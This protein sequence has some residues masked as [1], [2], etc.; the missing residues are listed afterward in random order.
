ML[1]LRRPSAVVLARLAAA[2]S[3]LGLT[4]PEVGATATAMPAR[5]W[6]GRWRA[7]L[8]E[9]SEARLHRA[10]D[11]LRGWAAQRGAGM[12]VVPDEPVRPD[13]TFAL[14]LPLPLGWATAAGRVVYV[15]D[16]PERFGFAYGTLPAHP[17]RG[18]EA[19]HVARDGARLVFTV[20]AFS[21]PQH[22]LARLGAPVARLIQLRTNRAY[23]T[24][25]RAA[26][27]C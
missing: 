8:G 1:Y 25:M 21:R 26:V 10:S 11:A 20:H 9:Y 15:T 6:H 4:Y 27:G 19:F 23:L 7:D 16:E 13:L 24:A 2:Q 17:E 12:T 5:Y 3:G 22:P 14:A 18:E